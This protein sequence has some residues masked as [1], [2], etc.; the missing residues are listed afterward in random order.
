MPVTIHLDLADAATPQLNAMR[1]A[2]GSLGLRQ[3]VTRAVGNTIKA[4]LILINGQRPNALGGKRTNFYQRAANSLTA[5]ADATGGTVTIRQR[6]FRY[7]V[8]GGTVR[9][10]GKASAVTGRPIRFLTIPI[11]PVAHGKVPSDFR[12]TPLFLLRSKEK[13]QVYLARSIGRGKSARVEV[14]YILKS[15]VTK[16]PDP[17]ILPPEA[18]LRA[19]VVEQIKDTLS[20]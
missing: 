19:A 15:S 18:E 14:L 20:R 5:E 6:G 7:Q 9:A 3:R 8:K 10:S 17:T 4:R 2:L 13:N 16:A 12:T 1:K 11:N